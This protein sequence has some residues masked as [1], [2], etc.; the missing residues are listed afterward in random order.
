MCDSFDAEGAVSIITP[1]CRIYIPMGE[2]VD[3]KAELERLGKEAE[4]VKGE[5][6]RLEA[7][8]GNEGFTS[9]APAAVVE[10]E[11]RKLASYKEKLTGIED[12][13]KKL[14]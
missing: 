8:L 14:K 7:K 12:A 10:A 1:A 4:K 9:K 13:V 2:L 5:I 6:A 3:T 11:R